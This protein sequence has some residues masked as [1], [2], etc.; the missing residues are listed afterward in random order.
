MIDWAQHSAGTS[1][2]LLEDTR[3]LPHLKRSWI[4]HLRWK[5]LKVKA[6]IKILDTWAIVQQ[7][8]N[9][10]HIIDMMVDSPSITEEQ[11]QK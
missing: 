4:P 10:K 6:T 11:V 7:Q 9:D 5:L 3:H 1:I 8:E 2:P